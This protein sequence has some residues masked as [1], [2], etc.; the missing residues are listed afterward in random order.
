MQTVTAQ[1][2]EQM[3]TSEDADA[4]DS[5]FDY[6]SVLLQE[7]A[8]SL[9]ECQRANVY[10][11][12]AGDHITIHKT[13]P[14]HE[15]ILNA[16]AYDVS[17]RLLPENL[18]VDDGW[19]VRKNP[20]VIVKIVDGR[21]L[22]SSVYS[23]E[24]AESAYRNLVSRDGWETIDAVRNGRVLLLSSELTEAPYLQL[25]AMLMIA[26]TADPVLYEDVDPEEALKA[27]SEEASG[28]IPVGTYYYSGKEK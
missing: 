15:L 1:E 27:L 25:A 11:E 10:W 9:Y 28:T 13:S 2:A 22:G 26:E 5:V 3:G 8:G 7:R 18:Q 16:G 14:E 4:A 21:V 6:Y 23:V 20:G 24:A 19:V 12:T 17:A